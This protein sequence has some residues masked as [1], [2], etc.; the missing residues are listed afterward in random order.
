ML[1]CNFDNILA[2]TAGYGPVAVLLVVAVVFAAGT[3]AVSHIFGPSRKGPVKLMPYESGVDPVGDARRRFNPRFF[4]VAMIFL[5]FDV[6]IVF[7]YPW[8]ASFLQ[9][10]KTSAG[11]AISSGWLLLEV[12]IFTGILLLAYL[13][14]LGRGA[15]RWR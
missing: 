6:E 12:L 4:V 11:G 14:A 8:A 2:V 5:V 10:V 1:W 13:Y 3:V 9:Q 15:L 7:F